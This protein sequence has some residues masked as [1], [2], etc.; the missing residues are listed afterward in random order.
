MLRTVAAKTS[1]GSGPGFGLDWV[2]DEFG[3]SKVVLGGKNCRGFPH[4]DAFQVCQNSHRG[5]KSK[6]KL[7]KAA[8][9]SGSGQA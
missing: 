1:P 5:G 9:V 6:I 4:N 7:H 2:G 8:F 3:D